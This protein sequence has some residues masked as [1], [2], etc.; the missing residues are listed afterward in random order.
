MK[1]TDLELKLSDTSIPR[2]VR[3]LGLSAVIRLR[4]KEYQP[5]ITNKKDFNLLVNHLGIDNYEVINAAKFT[6][7]RVTDS[8]D[9]DK[10]VDI[11]YDNGNQVKI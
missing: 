5:I 8:N 6:F 3:D 1:S 11:Q 4:I 10:F 2:F 7:I 9:S